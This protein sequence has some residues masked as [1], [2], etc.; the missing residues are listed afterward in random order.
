MYR[1]K[2]REEE[3]VKKKNETGFK[4][5]IFFFLIFIVRFFIISVKG[6]PYRG[7]GGGGEGG[8]RKRDKVPLFPVFFVA[9]LRIILTKFPQLP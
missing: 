1:I 5:L 8:H 3:N 9:P 7:K 2:E 6:V 4:N